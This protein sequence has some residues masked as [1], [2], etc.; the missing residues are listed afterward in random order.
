MPLLLVTIHSLV[1]GH[2]GR[3]SRKAARLPVVLAATDDAERAP[4]AA[5]HEDHELEL[6]QNDI[7]L[8]RQVFAVEAETIAKA[9]QDL[10]NRA[11]RGASAETINHYVRALRAFGRWLA[12]LRLHAFR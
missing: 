12:R 2:R 9:V 11:T 10:A 4:A 5:V 6:W 8:A 7:R 3:G 1:A